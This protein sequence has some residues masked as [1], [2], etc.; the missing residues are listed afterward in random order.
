MATDQEVAQANANAEA[1]AVAIKSIAMANG[2]AMATMGLMIE[3]KGVVSREELRNAFDVM[4]SVMSNAKGVPPVDMTAGIDMIRNVRDM[5]A[6]PKA[7]WKPVVVPG[8]KA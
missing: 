1:L 6:D 8:G 7:T 3:G 4:L 2:L 5:L